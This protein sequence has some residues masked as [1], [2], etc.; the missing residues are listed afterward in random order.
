MQICLT[1]LFYT[2]LLRQMN[3]MNESSE[4]EKWF[5]SSSLPR[6]GWLWNAE[7]SRHGSQDI[8]SRLLLP[9]LVAGT[10]SYPNDRGTT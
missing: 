10:P 3:Q 2:G 6:H 1:R 4:R 7:H 5:F 9:Q 8:R